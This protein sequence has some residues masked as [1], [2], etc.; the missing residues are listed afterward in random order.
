MMDLNG[1]KYSG[2]IT[3]KPYASII[4]LPD[5]NPAKYS[6]EYKT[7]C[8]GTQYEG[9][10]TT[11]KYERT[12]KSATGADSVVTTYLTVNP[13]FVITETIEIPEGESYMGWTKEGVYTRNLN[14]VTGCD[15]IVRTNLVIKPAENKQGQ[16]IPL[17][18]LPVNQNADYSN[19]MEITVVYAGLESFIPD[20]GDEIAVFCGEKCIGSMVLAKAID[21][22]DESSYITLTVP[23][24]GKSQNG[25]VSGD[26]ISFRIW[27]ADEQ[28]EYNV[29]LVDYLD[30][31]PEWITDGKF[32]RGS[33]A[34]VAL[35]FKEQSTTATHS[36][37]LSHTSVYPNP[38]NGNFK[39][40]FSEL[41]EQ[42][43]QIRI[44][45][46]QGREIASRLA[47]GT[48]EQFNLEGQ[49]NGTYLVSAVSGT[50][51]F[52]QKIIIN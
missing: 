21:E 12:L 36:I 26:S 25:F 32:Q 48:I 7:I 10:G 13:R 28:A 27:N 2:S 40:H 19:G 31:N 45:D 37:S 20:A 24:S 14:A 18:F 44:F 33:S 41:P 15:S 46:L 17:H 6:V 52:S 49:Q 35:S 30:E 22:N 5:P 47:E 8:E 51:R 43:T 16:I 9:W 4:L 39:V 38:S 3:L 50:N 11:G 1:I 23:E 34:T 29:P 42:G